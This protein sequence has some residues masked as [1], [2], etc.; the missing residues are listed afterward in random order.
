MSQLS[1]TGKRV[2]LPEDE[3]ATL[4]PRLTVKKLRRF[5]Y[6]SVFY[7]HVR[8]GYT[9]EYHTT[10]FASLFPQVCEP[11]PVSYVNMLRRSDRTTYRRIHFDVA[12]V[13]A[14]VESVSNYFVPSALHRPLADP[15]TWWIDA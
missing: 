15:P 10:D 1:L 5:S 12:W 13:A 4:D 9:H 6:G 8:P 11:A 7:E 2:D 3:L 14:V